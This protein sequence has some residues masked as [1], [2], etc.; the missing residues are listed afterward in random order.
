M[1]AIGRFLFAGLLGFI[2]PPAGVYAI[3]FAIVS[4]MLFFLVRVLPLKVSIVVM[5]VELALFAFGMDRIFG[6]QAG[7]EIQILYLVFAVFIFETFPVWLRGFM[8]VLPFMMMGV[9]AL[10]SPSLEPIA[11]L[12]QTQLLN[13]RIANILYASALTMALMIHFAIRVQ[14]QRMQALRQAEQRRHLIAALSHE[15]KTPIAAMLTRT[16]VAL[17]HEP[18]EDSHTDLLRV[19]ER[20]LRSMSRLVRRMLDHSRLEYGDLST[21]RETIEPRSL[22]EGC[23]EEHRLAAEEK[24][25][26]W[27]ISCEPG[28]TL[29]SNPDLLRLALNNLV[30]N[31]V[32]YSKEHGVIS[33]RV[34]GTSPACFIRVQDE[35]IGI[36]KKDLPN[37]FEPFFRGDQARSRQEGSHGLGLSLAKE[38][39]ER[40]GGR[41]EV[42]SEPGQ[43]SSFSICL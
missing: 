23:V 38:A 22:V 34:S 20:N 18:K 6:W 43:G 14:K 33:I 39:I 4:G 26:R 31:A 9:I 5:G 24:A 37:I 3:V 16:Q 30:G 27:N 41:I 13:L 29:S 25:L 2:Y 8:A 12:N 42:E 35:G 36:D 19:M 28:L 11:A 1:N 21:G 32:R 7:F 15:M 40:I 17:Q 10:H